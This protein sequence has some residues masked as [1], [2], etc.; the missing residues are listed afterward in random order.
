MYELG[1]LYLNNKCGADR[2]RAFIWF[3]I[4][5]RFGSSEGKAEADRLAHALTPAQQ[6]QAHLIV[7][8]WIKD[9]PGA[10]KSEDEE[11][12]EER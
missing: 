8:R 3:T 12:K 11:E 7:D 5:G 6:K 4:G 1:K 2:N 9:H 10:D